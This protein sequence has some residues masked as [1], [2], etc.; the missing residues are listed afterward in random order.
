MGLEKAP[1]IVSQ[2]IARAGA[3]GAA[4]AAAACVMW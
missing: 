1:K 2:T 3:A 4:R